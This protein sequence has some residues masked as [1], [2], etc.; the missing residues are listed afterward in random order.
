[1][2]ETPPV[3]HAIS[4]PLPPDVDA[5][6]EAARRAVGLGYESAWLADT[7]GPDPFVLAAALARS[8][9]LRVGIGVSP[10]FTRTP[11]VFAAMSGTLGQ[12]MPGR[13]VLG[14]GCSSETIVDRWNGVPF[15]KPVARVRE[16]V[17]LVRA[18]LKGERSSF[19][20]KTVRSEGFRLA[21]LP[22]QPVPI[23]V[24]ALKP[25][26]LRLAGE[27]GEGV[28][29]NLFPARALPAMLSEVARGVAK[30]GKSPTGM[31]VVCRFQT[32]VT[33]DAK[34]ARALVR[35]FMTGYF[36]T[37][38]YN[39]FAE[40]CGFAEEARAMREAWAKRDRERA[41]AAFTDE[42]IDAITLI[43]TETHCRDRV[44][45]FVDAGLT[46]PMYHAFASD[47]QEAW[48]TLVALAPRK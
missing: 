11:A 28:V 6:L 16:T 34:G 17:T 22:P 40:W 5:S 20:G 23:Y 30:A 48:R 1:V 8:V 31:E 19:Q 42:M 39:A 7:A 26:M 24:G 9:P 2:A 44:A 33:D 27:V 37:S 43:G 46:T 45:E 21:S 47:P 38:V 18:M 29:V 13:F 36:T 10:A 35:R 15:E 41:E 12:L 4:L 32:W 25:P 14:L 3:R